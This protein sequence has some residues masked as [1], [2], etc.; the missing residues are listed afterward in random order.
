MFGWRPEAKHTFRGSQVGSRSSSSTL[1]PTAVG[2]GL[3]ELPVERPKTV[4]V[5]AGLARAEE[6]VDKREDACCCCNNVA[7]R[8][9]RDELEMAVMETRALRGGTELV[10]V[11]VEEEL[12]NETVF[13]G[14]PTE[15]LKESLE[16][17]I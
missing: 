4:S 11:L 15:A 12:E 9:A 5:N 6:G 10:N 2:L 13:E 16:I 8:A 14:A 1:F 17:R 3:I 7:S